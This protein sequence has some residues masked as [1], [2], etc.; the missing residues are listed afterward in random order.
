MDSQPTMKCRITFRNTK[1]KPGFKD[2]LASQVEETISSLEKKGYTLVI[3]G[4]FYLVGG[5]RVGGT[6]K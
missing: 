1:G 3:P 2:V 6:R 5:Y 4:P